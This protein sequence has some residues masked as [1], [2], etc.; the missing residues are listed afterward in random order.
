MQ[1]ESCT[2]QSPFIAW[3]LAVSSGVRGSPIKPQVE[4]RRR[5]RV[6]PARGHLSNCIKAA[7]SLKSSSSEM[8]TFLSALPFFCVPKSDDL[9]NSFRYNH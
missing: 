9:K 2:A 1:N 4:E 8:S 3:L 6:R 5:E 7:G